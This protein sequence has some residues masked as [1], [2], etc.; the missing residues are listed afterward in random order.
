MKKIMPY[1]ALLL[2]AA[3]RN[4]AGPSQ[5]E[6]PG[7]PAVVWFNGL[8]ATI[9][10]YY[11]EADSLVTGAWYTGSSPNHMVSIG[12]G[13]FA[14]LSSLDAELRVT[15]TAET[16]SWETTA[17]LPLGTNPYSM[18]V[19]GDTAWVSLLLADSVVRVSLTTGEVSGG[20][21]T[22][23]NPSGIACSGDLVFVSYSNWP[24]TSS[25]GG[26]SVFR[27]DTGEE[28]RWLNTGV[29]THWLVM[30]PS[31]NLHCYSTTYQNDGAITVMNAQ[32]PHLEISS[33]MCGGAPGEAVLANGSFISPDGWGEGGL[34]VYDEAGNWERIELDTACVGLAFHGGKIYATSF[35][36]N[37]VYVLDPETFET[38]LWMQSGGE[39]PQGIVAVDP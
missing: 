3:C 13:R 30:Q 19:S 8:S 2:A 32:P 37:R 9:D 35:G 23:N 27:S 1:A 36:E 18:A 4:A 26:V 39:G 29:N 14:V 11:T 25:P 10:A 22:R 34:I 21:S 15:G 17:L 6:G 28:T 20:F 24:E 16:G 5:G 7:G 12:G 33:F 31:G 38:T